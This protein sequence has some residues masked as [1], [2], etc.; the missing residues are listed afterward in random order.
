MR[1]P[2]WFLC[3]NMFPFLAQCM[4]EYF[5]L[6]FRISKLKDLLCTFSIAIVTLYILFNIEKNSNNNDEKIHSILDDLDL[7]HWFQIYPKSDINIL[8][9]DGAWCW[10]ADPRAVFYE[11]I[12]SNF[13]QIFKRL[14]KFFSNLCIIYRIS[15]SKCLHWLGK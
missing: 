13:S 12:F 8:T 3:N 5:C 14:K 15:S 6:P 2:K 7:K 10:F 1:Y 9:P 11:G 4:K